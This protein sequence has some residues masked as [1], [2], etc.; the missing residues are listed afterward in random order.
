[1]TKPLL[2]KNT[3]KN[4]IEADAMKIKVLISLEAAGN[5]SLKLEQAQIDLQ[6]LSKVQ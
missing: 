4:T 2:L 6:K 3:S 5:L 1:M